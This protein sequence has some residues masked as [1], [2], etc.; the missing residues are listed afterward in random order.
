MLFLV[1]LA[2]CGCSDLAGYEGDWHGTPVTD[3]ALLAGM[4]PDQN[5]VLHLDNVDRLQ[6]S[7]SITLGTGALGLRP[8]PQAGADSLGSFELPDSPLKSYI[9]VAPLSDGDAMAIVSLYGD[10]RVD[11][12]L[13]RS[14]ALY[15]VFHLTR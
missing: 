11:L 13:I 1:A 14:D 2:A 12:R 3:P 7:G 6:V 10:Q 8:V 9:L 4:P 15:A 5:V